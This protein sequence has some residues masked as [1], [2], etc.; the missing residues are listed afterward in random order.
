MFFFGMV[1]TPPDVISQIL[2]ALPMYLLF[3]IGLLLSNEKKKPL[4][5]D[6]KSAKYKKRV[7][8]LARKSTLEKINQSQLIKNKNI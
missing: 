4:V 7:Q 6:L 2:L 3:E 1:L 5:K 8:T